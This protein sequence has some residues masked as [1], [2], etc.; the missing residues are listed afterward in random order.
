MTRRLVFLIGSLILVLATL[1]GAVSWLFLQPPAGRLPEDA[2]GPAARGSTGDGAVPAAALSPTFNAT[3]ARQTLNARRTD[4][5]I[6]VKSPEP[7]SIT[8]ATEALAVTP[9]VS[10]GL[11]PAATAGPVYVTPTPESRIFPNPQKDMIVAQLAK[12]WESYKSRFI[13]SSGRVVD[14]TA[15][16][17]TTSEGQSYALLRAVWQNDRPTFDKVLDWSHKNLQVVS[18]GNLFAYKWGKNNTTGT[19]NIMDTSTASDADSDIALALVLASRLWNDQGYLKMALDI[20]GDIWT[21]EVVQVQNVPYLTAGDWATGKTE[22]PLNPSYLSPASMRIFAALDPAHD[23]TGLVDS[24]YRVIRG[25][26]EA[27]LDT[28]A[29]AKLPPNWCGL[30]RQTAQFTLSPDYPRLDTA[31][32]YDAFRTMWRVALDY[33][34]FGEKR[35]LDFLTWSDTLRSKYKQAGKLVAVY[36]HAGNQL[37]AQED[38]AV[39]A[40]DLANFWLTDPLSASDIV[41]KKLLPAYNEFG[42]TQAGWGDLQNYYIQNWVWF[43][44]A[45]YAGRLPDFSI[46]VPLAQAAS[47]T[48]AA[49]PGSTATASAGLGR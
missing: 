17:I 32:G 29:P 24:S 3:A 13:E 25:C 35:A 8:Y 15:G 33:N 47:T 48:P 31:Y 28:A 1:A 18:A 42:G 23:W 7:G 38:L 43:G 39:Y 30:N 16:N 49:V 2:A 12:T 37:Q 36:D 5:P 46:T 19:W 9:A 22:L 14:P 44:L 45:L 34:W 10:P 41:D 27:G 11:T 26:A 6:V 40:G 4:T 20:I 21:F